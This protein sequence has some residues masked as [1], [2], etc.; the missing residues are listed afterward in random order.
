M[1]GASKA[2][3]CANCGVESTYFKLMESRRPCHADHEQD[4]AKQCGRLYDLC[5]QDYRTEEWEVMTQEEKGF[6]WRGMRRDQ[7]HH[8]GPQDGRQGLGVGRPRPLDSARR[9]AR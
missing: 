1:D 3:K 7:P 8:A 2:V 6:T 4:V 5:E 9:V